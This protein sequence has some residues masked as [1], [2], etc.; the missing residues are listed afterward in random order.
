VKQANDRLAPIRRAKQELLEH[1]GEELSQLSRHWQMRDMPALKSAL[2]DYHERRKQL[3][4]CIV[5]LL[6]DR[7]GH[8]H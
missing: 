6:S 3:V 4:P 7:S 5:A 8:F 2:H 1:T